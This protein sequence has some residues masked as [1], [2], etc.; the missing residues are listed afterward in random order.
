[1][2]RL[3]G[4]ACQVTRCGL[5]KLKLGAYSLL[6]TLPKANVTTSFFARGNGPSTMDPLSSAASVFGV[7]SLAGQIV[8]GIRTIT[9]LWGEVRDAPHF[10]RDALYELQLLSAV[11]ER[12]RSTSNLRKVDPLMVESL[13]QCAAK[14]D[15]FIEFMNELR[16]SYQASSRRLRTW[17]AF[18]A[19]IQTD[20]M[21]KFRV[22]VGETKT[23]LFLIRQ[24]LA[25]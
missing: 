8:N 6:V 18:K 25:E 2:W 15:G 7:V 17:T 12:V 9:D 24:D 1:M 4:V 22:D 19:A 3:A 16:P 11:L 23:T 20:K 10:I 13:K 14:V 21:N 5:C